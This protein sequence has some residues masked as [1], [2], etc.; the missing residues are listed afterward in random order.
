MSENI[1]L[2]IPFQLACL[3]YFSFFI[4]LNRV[5]KTVESTNGEVD[6]YHVFWFWEKSIQSSLIKYNISNKFS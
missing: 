6:I 1:V 5:F 4:K 3:Y 2:L